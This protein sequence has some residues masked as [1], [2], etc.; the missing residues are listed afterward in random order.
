MYNVD[1]FGKVINNAVHELPSKASIYTL[2]YNFIEHLTN[3]TYC[4]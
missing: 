3:C 1:T 2:E 4:L